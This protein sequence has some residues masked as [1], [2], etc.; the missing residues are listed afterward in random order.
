MYVIYSIIELTNFT[1]LFQA[2]QRI[3]VRRL[4]KGH[5]FEQALK[6]LKKS[7]KVQLCPQHK[8]CK[9]FSYGALYKHIQLK[10]PE[11]WE[12]DESQIEDPIELIE[13][14]SVEDT[15]IVFAADNLDYNEDIEENE[16]SK[17]FDDVKKNLNEQLFNE[18]LA[19]VKKI[20]VLQHSH[21]LS[22]V[23]LNEVGTAII[24]TVERVFVGDTQKNQFLGYMK[25]FISS[26]HLQKEFMRLCDEY[27]ATKKD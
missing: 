20:K 9:F 8:K 24:E 21:T 12:S 23:A 1:I 11:L 14:N 3:K 25:K 16:Y 5:P 22:N 15:P 19:F 2:T 10:H 4:K 18:F 7:S 6:A 17:F 13:D 26:S 27:V